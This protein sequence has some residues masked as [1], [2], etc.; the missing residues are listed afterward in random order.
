[1]AEKK[2]VKKR[3]RTVSSKE[4]SEVF[5]LKEIIKDKEKEIKTLTEISKSIVSGRY[6]E[7][8][9]NIVVSLTAEMMGSKICSIMVLDKNQKEL[10]IIATQSLS[11]GYRHKPNIPVGQS[12]SGRVVIEK[13]PIT[14]LDVTKEPKYSFR[15]M[16]KK[17]GLKSMLAVPMIFHGTV[18]G[19]INVYTAKE[20]VFGEN[21]IRILQAVAN[22][23]AIGIESVKLAEETTLAKEAL[24][25]RKFIDRAKG[26]LMNRYKMPEDT[27]YKSIHRKSMD[28]R[29]TM[30][31]VA[32]AIILAEE[33]EK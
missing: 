14:V 25:T 32:E 4:K 11:E 17:E 27:A 13:N 21:E 33:I 12:V 31:E 28:S 16:A 15:D 7:E 22:Q 24:E 9:L 6:L 8:V 10:K 2:T 23:A 19:V 1:M 20:H 29:K 30:K 26:I 3:K 18:M 5:K